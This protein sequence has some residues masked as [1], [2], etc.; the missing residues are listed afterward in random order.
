MRLALA[1]ALALCACEA[2]P[3]PAAA[4]ASVTDASAPDDSPPP[5]PPSEPGRHTVTVVETRQVIPGPGLPGETPP[6]NSNNNLDVVRHEGRVYLAWRTAPDHFA[7]AA[8]R[9]FV[10]SSADERSWRFHQRGQHHV[11]VGR[12][13]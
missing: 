9:I 5:P 12:S 8:T 11:P 13:V 10:V 4:D 3:S 2:P 6:G 7:S 1:A